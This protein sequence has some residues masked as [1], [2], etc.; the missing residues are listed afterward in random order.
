[1]YKVLSNSRISLNTHIDVAGSFAANM[2]LFEATGVGSCLVTDYKSNLAD[3][4]KIDEEV[5]TYKSASECISKI[6]FLL[7][8][9]N[10]RKKIAIAGQKRT[11]SDH[12]YSNRIK[13]F[14]KFL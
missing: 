14:I 11:L 7:S 3:F 8:N 10:E 13:T 6:K 4:F 1:M 12:T 5:V 2:R 9:E